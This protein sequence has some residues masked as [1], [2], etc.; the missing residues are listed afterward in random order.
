VNTSELKFWL[1]WYQSLDNALDRASGSIVA[2]VDPSG[3]VHHAVEEGLLPL[4]EEIRE[5]FQLAGQT[6]VFVPRPS[7]GLQ[8]WPANHA[9]AERAGPLLQ[10]VQEPA[11]LAQDNGFRV[12][13]PDAPLG[14]VRL[15]ELLEAREYCRE[16]SEKAHERCASWTRIVPELFN[17]GLEKFVAEALPC[18]DLL[19]AVDVKQVLTGM[20]LP[21]EIMSPF[22][23]YLDLQLS[24]HRV[25]RREALVDDDQWEEKEK[26]Q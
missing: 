19:R 6:D 21:L 22:L 12:H 17:D 14:L 18:F 9:N 25:V 2:W 10:L 13:E 24:L 20:S 23:P 7:E 3:D 8:V 16:V 11:Y 1:D 4:L 15:I 5:L 26:L